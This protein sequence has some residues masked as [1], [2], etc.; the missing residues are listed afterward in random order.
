MGGVTWPFS[1]RDLEAIFDEDFGPF[2]PNRFDA[3]ASH[4]RDNSEA[5]IQRELDESAE[6]KRE[7]GKR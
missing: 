7:R 4:N 2:G 3:I 1:Q 6:Y 5:A